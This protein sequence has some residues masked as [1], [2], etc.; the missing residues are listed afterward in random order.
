MTQG[1]TSNAAC[2][3][4]LQVHDGPLISGCVYQP[5]AYIK[6]HNFINHFHI[7][8]W[9]RMFLTSIVINEAIVIIDE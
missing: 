6:T 7:Q 8:C 5:I 4:K 2:E 9:S 1:S 3:I